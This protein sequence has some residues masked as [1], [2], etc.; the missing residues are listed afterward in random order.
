M[1][2]FYSRKWSALLL[3]GR[4]LAAL[5]RPVGL[6]PQP[7]PTAYALPVPVVLTQARA[8]LP[9]S[10]IR[11]LGA[12][13]GRRTGLSRRLELPLTVQSVNIARA[14]KVQ[15]DRPSP[16]PRPYRQ[17]KRP[18]RQPRRSS[19]V[20]ATYKAGTMGIRAQGATASPHQPA[21]PTARQPCGSRRRPVVA[22]RSSAPNLCG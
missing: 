3:H 19:V 16:N 22:R 18:S 6:R 10:E 11:Q 17:T 1:R 13:V 12:V 7:L 4:T 15:T 14:A 5:V 8:P 20:V 21:E 9:G 2:A